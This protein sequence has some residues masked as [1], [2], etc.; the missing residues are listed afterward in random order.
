MCVVVYNLDHITQFLRENYEDS[1]PRGLKTLVIEFQKAASL[2]FTSRN[3]PVPFLDLVKSYR[4][5]LGFRRR[6]KLTFKN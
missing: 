5:K 6:A 2:G 1:I 3:Q 4:F